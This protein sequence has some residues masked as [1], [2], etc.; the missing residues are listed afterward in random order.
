MSKLVQRISNKTGRKP[1]NGLDKRPEDRN[2]LGHWRKEDSISFNYRAYLRLKPSELKKIKRS[3]LT[4]AQDIALQAVLKARA[5]LPYLKEVSDRT[6]GKPAQAVMVAEVKP[7][8]V[9]FVTID[10]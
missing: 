9:S 7:L 2:S 8:N 10:G 4:L 6:E 5:D 1:T 3:T